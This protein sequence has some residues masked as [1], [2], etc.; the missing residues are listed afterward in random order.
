MNEQ[1]NKSSS[2]PRCG[3]SIPANA[4]DALCPACLMSQALAM[5]DDETW[6]LDGVMPNG[7]PPEGWLSGPVPTHAPRSSG[8]PSDHL[9]VTD[10]VAEPKQ[11]LR[12][13]PRDFGDYRLLRLLGSGGMGKVFEAEH[14]P[15]GRRIAL[16]RLAM[17]LDSAEM[18]KRFLREGRLAA[19]VTHP[20]SLYVFGSEDIDGTPVITM[21]I[22]AGG[23][24]KDELDKHGP[25]PVRQA[26]DAILDVIA[27]LQAAG[28]VGVLHRDIKPSNCFVMPDGSVKIGDY[29]L[30]IS[31]LRREDTHLT[32]SGRIMGTP[33]YASPE[34]LRGDELDL[35]A[36]I[37][38]VGA[39]LY[40]LLT[41]KA[42]FD[43]RNAVQVVANAVKMAPQKPSELRRDLPAGLE[44]I[45]CRCLEKEPGSRYADYRL[46]SEALLPFSSR[47]N[48]SVSLD[49]RSAAGWI[50]FLIA[51]FVPYIALRLWVGGGELHFGWLMEKTLYSARFYLAF[52]GFGMLYFTV[53]EG[54]FGGGFGKKHKGLL[55]VRA[56]DSGR[57]GPWRAW[58]RIA[59]PLLSTEAVRLPLLFSFITA[60]RPEE[61][62]FW[63]VMLY[64]GLATACPWVPILLERIFRRAGGHV[65]PWDLLSGTRVIVRPT[66]ESRPSVVMDRAPAASGSLSDEDM[67]LGPFEIREE[68]VA[69]LWLRGVDPVLDR[70]VWLLKRQGGG[71]SESRRAVSRPGRA[72]WLQ[73]TKD[74]KGEVW[75]AYEGSPGVPFRLRAAEGPIPWSELRHWLHDLASELWATEEADG[76]IDAG[77]PTGSQLG[78][79]HIW[80]TT[81]GRALLLDLP[82]PRAPYEATSAEQA[83]L[84]DVGDL[85]GKQRFLAEVASSVE[86]TSLPLHA[87]PVLSNLSEGRFEKLS[88]L[89]G[90]LRGL[91][92]RPAALSRPARAGA[93]FLLPVY[94]FLMTLVGSWESAAELENLFPQFGSITFLVLFVIAACAT[95]T[96]LLLIPFQTTVGHSLFRLAVVDAEGR[97]A[98]RRRL[99]ARWSVAW[100]PLI[101]ATASSIVLAP[102]GL[103][104]P[105]LRMGFALWLAAALYAALDPHRGLH[106]RLAGTWVVLR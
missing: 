46:L 44:S 103:A 8:Q 89:A 77:D 81:S 105:W 66:A 53:V 12:S 51:F 30:S 88:F 34:Q 72:R 94:N 78:L 106:D 2:C 39:T 52:L 26:V 31:S 20:H 87:R 97:S 47:E 83:E 3:S 54:F 48:E 14:Q 74:A 13:L 42:P 70:P 79:D 104:S 32:A 55:V 65:T 1:L 96:Q 18:R 25:L 50:D 80:L 28:E 71:P 59:V 7:V 95:A 43:G 9:S 98:S 62:T 68:I 57:P 101:L 58:I 93:L 16:K 67:R 4:T 82:W 11:S 35:R 75:D 60:T 102:S 36:D 69:G 21:E 22:A 10:L 56:G 29:G 24:L 49:D 40:T 92:D 38:S 90:T 63:Q 27:G 99:L 5:P 37:Y 15:T 76:Q 91:M 33:A 86:S 41:G 6:S 19:S 64:I 85:A 61:L 45:I 23:T 84:Y 100:G 17:R 73:K